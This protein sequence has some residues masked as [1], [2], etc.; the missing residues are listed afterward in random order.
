MEKFALGKQ[1]ARMTLVKN[2][3]GCDQVIE[4]LRSVQEPFVLVVC[5]NDRAADGTDI[6]WIRDAQFEGLQALGSRLRQVIVSGDRALDMRLRI[7]Y[8]GIDDG[9][10]RVERDY[11]ALVESL[12]GEELPIFLMP[13]YTAMLELRQAVVHKVGGQEFWEK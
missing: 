12:S 13:T 7:K 10:I 3:A 2:P 9:R 6:S 5:L 4:F 11:G 1:G 8:A